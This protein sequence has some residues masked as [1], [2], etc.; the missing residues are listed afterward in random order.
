VEPTTSF[1]T[2]AAARERSLLRTAYLL[3][4]DLHRAEDLVQD[5]FIKVA[6]R[7]SRL[8]DGN[9][10]A[11]ARTVIVRSNVSWWRRTRRER[12]VPDVPDAPSEG[13]GGDA[14]DVDRRLVLRRALARLT[15]KQRA[16]IVLR[17]YEDLS[18]PQVAAT[19]G[20]SVGTVKSQTAAAL[21]R[22]RTAAPE[23]T[24]F[25]GGMSS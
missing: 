4:G 20:V 22:L 3:T 17:F 9:P 16:V 8:V 5:A 14:G 23:L 18:E 19:L 12:V 2:W 13:D 15:R 6:L 7:W 25:I 11:Y 10:D 21:A 1:S 24:Q